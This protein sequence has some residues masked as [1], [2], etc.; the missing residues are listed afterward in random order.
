MST[1]VPDGSGPARAELE[2][3]VR[4]TLGCTCPDAVFERVE[5]REGPAL[6]CGGSVRRIA[7]GGRLLIHVVEGVSVEDVNRG[8][9]AWTLSGRIDRDDAR[10]NRFRLV[11]G[12]DGLST[13]DAGGIRDAFAA[14]CDDGD[15]RIHLHIVDSDAL[16]ALYL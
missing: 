12:L 9:H 8:I 1:S 4:G 13:G 10:M 6:P 15:D 16:R 14:A 3:F 7:I 5:M 2:R 11:I